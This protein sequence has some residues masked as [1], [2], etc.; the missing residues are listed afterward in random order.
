[1]LGLNVLRHVQMKMKQTLKA[2]EFSVGI[3]S[4][5]Q[6]QTQSESLSQ[7]PK[8]QFMTAE[9]SG[10]S[11]LDFDFKPTKPLSG[12]ASQNTNSLQNTASGM[13]SA[14]QSTTSPG[15]KLVSNPFEDDQFSQY[16]YSLCFHSAFIYLQY[17]I[18]IQSELYTIKS[19]IHSIATVS[20]VSE[21]VSPF[22]SFSFQ[23]F[24]FSR[25]SF[26]IIS[27]YISFSFLLCVSGTKTK[28]KIKSINTQTK[29][30][31]QF[32]FQVR[33]GNMNTITRMQIT[34]KPITKLI[35]AVFTWSG[36]TS[37]IIMKNCEPD[38]K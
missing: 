31:M 28:I 5:P 13:V 16:I 1:M 4:E 20:S 29:Y 35:A 26:G 3:D 36:N 7:Q 14:Q 8:L 19:K 23:A 33:S 27:F 18:I 32:Y 2:P 6:Q 38:E 34:Q 30:K 17:I 9:T 25:N 24:S 11:G 15:K 21:H 22:G 12:Q 10:I 37:P